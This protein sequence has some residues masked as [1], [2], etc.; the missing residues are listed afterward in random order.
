MTQEDL[1]I[2]IGLVGYFVVLVC[3]WWF[4]KND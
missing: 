3:L 4:Y 2:F 1:W